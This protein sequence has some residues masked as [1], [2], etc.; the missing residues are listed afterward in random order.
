[1]IAF[2]GDGGLLMCAGELVT[3][4]RERLDLV[5]VVFNDGALS[6]IDIKQRQ[7]ALDKAGVDIGAVDWRAVAGSLGMTAYAAYTEDELAAA[8]NAAASSRGPALVDVR[9]DPSGYP[10]I[11]RA[12]RG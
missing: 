10:A 2:T 6:L 1:V 7:R 4:V 9:T 8:L 3:A 5:V 12:V 11:L